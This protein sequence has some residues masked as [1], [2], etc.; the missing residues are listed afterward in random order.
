M[1]TE[2]LK[3]VIFCSKSN[4]HYWDTGIVRFFEQVVDYDLSWKEAKL[5]YPSLQKVQK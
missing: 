5:K 1:K 2:D 4:K 3:D